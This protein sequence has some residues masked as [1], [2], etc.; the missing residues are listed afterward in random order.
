MVNTVFYKK[1]VPNKTWFIQLLLYDKEF[2]LFCK[3]TIDCHVK[4]IINKLTIH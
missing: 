4:C 2:K 1:V 3:S